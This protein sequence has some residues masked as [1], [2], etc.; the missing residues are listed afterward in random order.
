LWDEDGNAAWDSPHPLFFEGRNAN[1]DS[2]TLFVDSGNDYVGIGTITP[3]ANLEVSE[4]SAQ[5][6]TDDDTFI[7]NIHG[8]HKNGLL[9]HSGFNEGVDIARF[10]SIGSGFIEIPRMVIKDFGRVGIGT[11]DPLDELHV[12]G[13]KATL[14]VQDDDDPQSYASLQDAAPTQLLL[15]KV[16][17]DGGTLIEIEPRPLDGVSSAKVRFFRATDTTGHKAVLFLRGDSSPAASAVIGVDG[18]NS[19]FQAH[20]GNL[21]IGTRNPERTLD[22][23]NGNHTSFRVGQTVDTALEIAHF[24]TAMADVPGSTFGM[25]MSGP[26][27]AHVVL[28]VP[29]NDVHDGF[30]VRVPTTLE[31]SPTVDRTAFAVKAGGNVGIGTSS[32]D[33]TAKLEVQGGPIKASGGLIIETRTND[34]PSPVTG[35]MWLRTDL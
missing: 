7:A 27:N 1:F 13:N 6:I 25:Q 10:S 8:Y 15:D 20:G 33:P 9:V 28:D 4:H 34:P 16:T 3:T 35:Q 21:G 18:A 14:I 11:D 5:V 29:G 31:L 23:I 26:V 2:G 19:Y 17:S 22:V 30:Y 32:P 12:R 24:N